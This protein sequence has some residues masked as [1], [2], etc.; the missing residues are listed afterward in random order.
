MKPNS[1]HHRP[2]FVNEDIETVYITVSGLL[3]AMAA[4]HWVRSHYP[5]YKC[6]IVTDKELQKKFNTEEDD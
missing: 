5:G 1:K 3:G 4:P 2:H 6:S